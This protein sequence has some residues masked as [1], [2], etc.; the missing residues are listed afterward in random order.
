MST[1]K[2]LNVCQCRWSPT[3]KEPFLC[4][5]LL[6][7]AVSFSFNFLQ[8]TASQNVLT[9]LNQLHIDFITK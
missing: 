6:F 3:K 9:Y 1:M 4:S 7:G 8:A 5:M 2:P